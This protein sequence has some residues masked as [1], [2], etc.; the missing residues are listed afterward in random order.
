MNNNNNYNNEPNIL[1]ERHHIPLSVYLQIYNSP[2]NQQR[3]STPQEMANQF[4][5]ADLRNG[6]SSRQTRRTTTNNIANNVANNERPH[7]SVYSFLNNNRNRNESSNNTNGSQSQQLPTGNGYRVETTLS[8][9]SDFGLFNSLFAALIN[10]TT[11][12]GTTSNQGLTME[13]IINYTTCLNYK[14]DNPALTSN[15]CSICTME[16]EQ[17]DGLRKLTRCGHYF[18]TRC[19]DRWLDEHNTCPLCRTNIIQDSTQTTTTPNQN[20]DSST[21]TTSNRDSNSSATTSAS[22]LFRTRVFDIN[23]VD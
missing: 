17:E 4:I 14:P 20:S 2:Q 3:L 11:R 10:P 15:S 23:G 13:Q 5:S 6:T 9:E 1:V 16:Y 19:I 18:H 21:T 8:G 12:A 7:S 22:Y